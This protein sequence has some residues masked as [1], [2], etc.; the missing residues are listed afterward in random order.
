MSYQFLHIAITSREGYWSLHQGRVCR[1][2]EGKWRYEAIPVDRG[3]V[4]FR[5]A[6]FNERSAPFPGDAM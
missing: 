4:F 1:R 3:G 6:S 2:Q 5:E